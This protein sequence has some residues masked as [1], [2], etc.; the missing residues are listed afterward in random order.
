M[1]G[2]PL[3]IIH[4]IAQN[5]IVVTG[6]E[7]SAG[8][9]L[10]DTMCTAYTD[11]NSFLQCQDLLHLSMVSKKVKS[12]ID[13]MIYKNL[14]L[15]IR[16]ADS[17]EFFKTLNLYAFSYNS[18][19]NERPWPQLYF[20]G[21]GKNIPISVMNHVQHLII[22]LDFDGYRC[23]TNDVPVHSMICPKYMSSLKEI[24]FLFD[25]SCNS[26][27]D[28]VKSVGRGLKEY[29][30]PIRSHM[31]IITNNQMNPEVEFL[32]LLDIYST[33][34]SFRLLLDSPVTFQQS[35]LTQLTMMENLKSLMITQEAPESLEAV[36]GNITMSEIHR[37][38]A[39]FTKLEKL[40]LLLG[41]YTS[42]QDFEW[43]LPENLKRLSTSL[44][45]FKPE[46][47]PNDLTMFDSVTFLEIGMSAS[48]F[49]DIPNLPFR[50]LN[51]FQLAYLSSGQIPVLKGFIDSNPGLV[52]LSFRS[53]DA[54][55]YPL[56]SPLLSK[57][58]NFESHNAYWHGRQSDF[59]G[60]SPINYLPAQCPNIRS[61]YLP[62]G[63]YR[64]L[65][66]QEILDLA[67]EEKCPSLS[68]IHVYQ[69]YFGYDSD[70][71]SL[72]SDLF[73]E[74]PEEISEILPIGVPLESFV[75]PVSTNKPIEGFADPSLRSY[76][77]DFD[78]LRKIVEV[79]GVE[80]CLEDVLNMK[81]E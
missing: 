57:T 50:N 19:L 75:F 9:H 64:S 79:Q 31:L 53:L 76:I 36:P 20:E 27:D 16:D 14:A 72:V 39:C 49:S 42:E 44:E 15:L 63:K 54:Q 32:K 12:I 10:Q 11:W 13:S 80:V 65:H 34:E 58:Q 8:L 24:T 47:L 45:M 37:S 3:E 18:F 62:F 70:I 6:D 17:E 81:E 68:T 41:D 61:M 28:D 22:S 40:E 25:P 5:L 48:Q 29:T 4:L 43:N 74:D 7:D 60:E 35:L 73:L 23:N 38:L 2:L 1:D 30:T 71:G 46:Y 69:A 26:Q 52:N 59:L 67:L 21:M 55:L 66:L 77:F 33:I 78:R 51:S 56:I